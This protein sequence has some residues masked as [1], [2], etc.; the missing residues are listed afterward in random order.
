MN[1]TDSF[2]ASA[3]P[4]LPPEKHDVNVAVVGLGLMGVTHLKAYQQIEGVRVAA[5][6]DNSRRPVNGMLAG[7][8][9]NTGG[10]DAIHLGPETRAYNSFD[11]LL[12][13]PAVDLISL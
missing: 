8:S 6:A 13:D 4:P 12:A 11:E 3:P 7:A 1:L 9:R 10:A 5:V 2:S